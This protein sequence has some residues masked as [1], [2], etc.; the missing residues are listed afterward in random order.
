MQLRSVTKPAVPLA[1]RPVARPVA[2]PIV[3]D[4]TTLGFT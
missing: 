2:V 3:D 1:P 4:D